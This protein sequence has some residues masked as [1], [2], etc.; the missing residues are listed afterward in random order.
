VAQGVDTKGLF[1]WI[2]DF[3]ANHPL[4]SV[5]DAAFALVSELRSRPAPGAMGIGRWR[6]DATSIF[7][8]LAVGIPLAWG[9]WI[10]MSNALLL[11][12]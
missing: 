9:V 1:G 7:A 4:D 10:T 12:R 11:F 3:C 2:D 5:A 6:L 8:W